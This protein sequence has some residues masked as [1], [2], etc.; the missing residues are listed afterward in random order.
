MLSVCIVAACAFAPPPLT[1]GLLTSKQ[2]SLGAPVHPAQKR[3]KKSHASASISMRH[4]NDEYTSTPARFTFGPE[5]AI[6]GGEGQIV[7]KSAARRAEDRKRARDAARSTDAAKGMRATSEPWERRFTF[8][9]DSTI[10]GGLSTL[11]RKEAA[12]IPSPAVARE[13]ARGGAQPGWFQQAAAEAAACA[14]ATT[15]AT[16]ARMAEA[17]VAEA[18]LAV[19]AA[20]RALED[21]HQTLEAAQHKASMLVAQSEAAAAEAALGTRA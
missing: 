14:A 12:D 1:V 16:H 15:L 13:R 5:S 11:W 9:P 10:G 19:K 8:T 6:G 2:G 3:G 17:E 18:A 20:E 4:W 7:A 21:A